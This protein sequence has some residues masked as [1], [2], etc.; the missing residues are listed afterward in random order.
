LL[1]QWPQPWAEIKDLPWPR[2]LV[3][4]LPQLQSRDKITCLWP[5]V[6]AGS[7]ARFSSVMLESWLETTI[8]IFTTGKKGKRTQIQRFKW[9]K[10]STG[11]VSTS[12]FWRPHRERSQCWS[13]QSQAFPTWWRRLLKHVPNYSRRD[14]YHYPT[15]PRESLPWFYPP[16]LGVSPCLYLC[17]IVDEWKPED[18][19]TKGPTQ[20][21]AEKLPLFSNRSWHWQLEEFLLR[22]SLLHLPGGFNGTD[23][24][25]LGA[26][27]T[28]S[29]LPL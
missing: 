17:C 5:V 7:S 8:F 10:H 3:T 29:I 6:S 21:R 23:Y 16:E 26:F 2:A 9:Q 27:I 15:L 28:P 18:C 22:H 24:P 14:F 4:L 1:D 20:L 19:L 12:S 13:C 25:W 11:T